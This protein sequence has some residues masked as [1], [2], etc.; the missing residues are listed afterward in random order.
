MTVYSLVISAQI[1]D[2]D[3]ANSQQQQ[4][5]YRLEERFADFKSV[6][7]LTLPE[8]WTIQ[9]TSEVPEASSVTGVGSLNPGTPTTALSSNVGGTGTPSAAGLGLSKTSIP[10]F[11]ITETNISHNVTLD[12]RNFEVK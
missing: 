7:N 1:S 2:S 11:D 9:F 6:D 4:T 10:Q 5:R 3:L 12:P 8:R